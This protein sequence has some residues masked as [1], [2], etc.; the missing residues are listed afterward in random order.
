MYLPPKGQPYD[1]GDWSLQAWQKDHLA[2][3]LLTVDEIL[4]NRWP[5][6]EKRAWAKHRAACERPRAANVRHNPSEI[7]TTLHQIDPPRGDFFALQSFEV[8]HRRFDG[9]GSGKL[10][11]EVFIRCARGSIGRG[12]T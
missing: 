6:I 3:T 7:D 10:K 12:H 4:R 5:I 1:V 2:P 9:A 11:R 8:S